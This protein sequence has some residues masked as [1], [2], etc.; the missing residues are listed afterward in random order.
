MES[1][2]ARNASVARVMFT[3]SKISA[4]FND[5]VQIWYVKSA[6]LPF[7][8]WNKFDP[9]VHVLKDAKARKFF[10]DV[11]GL[12]PGTLY[13]FRVALFEKS[14]KDEPTFSN[15]VN[16]KTFPKCK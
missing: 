10:A 7:E 13:Y 4:I 14:K 11:Q 3:S 2:T 9:I 6:D 1:I 5:T 12:E 15:T 8:I 16:M